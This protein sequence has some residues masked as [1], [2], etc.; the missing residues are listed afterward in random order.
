MKWT[1][2]LIF[3]RTALAVKDWHSVRMNSVNEPLAVVVPKEML[4]IDPDSASHFSWSV[5]KKPRI[6]LATF[7]SSRDIFIWVTRSIMRP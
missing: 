1:T 4:R 5:G 6:S 2:F 3:R 7:F